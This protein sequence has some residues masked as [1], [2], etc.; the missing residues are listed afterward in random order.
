MNKYVKV[1]MVV[2][3]AAVAAFAAGTAVLAEDPTL[4][5]AM[6]LFGG[7]RGAGRIGDFFERMREAV[8]SKLGVTAD[9]LDQAR[10]EA[11]EEVVEQ[12]VADGEITQEQADRMLDDEGA[13]WHGQRWLCHRMGPVGVDG[14]AHHAALAEALGITV[15]QFDEALAEGKTL[16][17]LAEELGLDMSDIRNTLQEARESALQKAVEEG[18]LTQEQ[19]DRLLGPRTRGVGGFGGG[20]CPGV[21]RFHKP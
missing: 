5:E 8:A 2:G 13:A 15:E 1:V 11:R 7:W 14:E 9:E 20:R 17:D 10:Q 16:G 19:A 4:P 6:G 3:L 21:P 12:A 18:R